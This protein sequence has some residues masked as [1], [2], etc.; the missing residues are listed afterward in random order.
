MRLDYLEIVGFKNLCDFTIDFDVESELPHTVLVGANGTGKSNLL[1]AL[2]AIFS[3]LHLKDEK[4][5]FGYKL[6]YIC[7][8]HKVSIKADS[9]GQYPSYTVNGNLISR[10]KFKA[11]PKGS[12]S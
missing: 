5:P 7:A 11:A 10:P 2:L 9:E 6:D 8:G 12:T 3:S 4:A 1:E